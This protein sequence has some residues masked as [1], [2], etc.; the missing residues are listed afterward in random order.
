MRFDRPLGKGAKG[1]HGRVYYS[2]AEYVP[3]V[4]IRFDFD[5]GRGLSRGIVGHH[6][7]EVFPE[8]SDGARLRHTVEA[9]CWG[10]NWMRWFFVI[11]PMHNAVLE[12][13]LDCAEMALTGQV[14]KPSRWSLYVRLLR[15]ASEKQ[16]QA[17]APRELRQLP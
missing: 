15:W 4:S 5:P 11:R 10:K 3:G 8:G 16:G 17:S 12:D 1:G 7:F 13:A 9:K 14:K 6:R 2:V